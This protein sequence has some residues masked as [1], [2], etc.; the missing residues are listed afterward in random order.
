M[1]LTA[2]Q[3]LAARYKGAF[4]HATEKDLKRYLQEHPKADPKNHTVKAPSEDKGPSEE[5]APEKKPKGEPDEGEG[6]GKSKE[7]PEKSKG[8]FKGLSDKA[9]AFVGKSSAAVQKFVSDAEHR[10]KVMEEA[11]KTILAS[12]KTY[13]KR[14]VATAKEEVHE[15]KEAGGALK[16]LA[17]GKK[18]DH[19]QKK[20]L[21]TVAI[22]MSIAVAAAAL[23]SSG[24]L[25]GAIAFGKGMAQKVALKA[26]AH[27]LEKIHLVQEITHIGHGAH[28]LLEVMHHLVASEQGEEEKRKIEKI[29][30][31]EAFAILVMQSVVKALREFDDND[32]SEVLE[33]ASGEASGGEQEKLSWK[34]SG[35]LP[36]R[37]QVLSRLG[38]ASAEFDMMDAWMGR[39]PSVLMAAR[40]E[41]PDLENR[42]RQERFVRFFTEGEE[43]LA[44]LEALEQAFDD[45][46]FDNSTLSM[47]INQVRQALR[48]P[49]KASIA[50][51]ISD[52]DFTPN[53]QTGRD[54]ITYG[55]DHLREWA[56]SVKDWAA[57]SRV[58]LKVLGSKAD[59]LLKVYALV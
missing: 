24:V 56:G 31:D 37:D 3:R 35:A 57:K 9:K 16:S 32:M 10:A 20:A 53:A 19:H 38:A 23:T 36:L 51:A 39:F 30:P 6:G 12:P 25:A 15:F 59:R 44:S 1:T 17:Q 28:E 34:V 8:F 29:P 47:V 46:T 40:S 14:L 45:M 42:V 2:S 26:A 11:G 18:L 13:A 43:V 33:E 21:K 49:R 54:D 48:I 22:H 55:I 27:S 50:Y 5:E 52:L 7:K 58:S 41:S 4:E